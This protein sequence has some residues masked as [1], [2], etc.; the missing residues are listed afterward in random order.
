[1]SS[2][3]SSSIED[4]ET[5]QYISSEYSTIPLPSMTIMTEILTITKTKEN[6]CSECK[7]LQY[8]QYSNQFREGDF[9]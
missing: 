2:G 5:M 1:M 8:V 9:C 4:Y 7:L 6:D 3:P